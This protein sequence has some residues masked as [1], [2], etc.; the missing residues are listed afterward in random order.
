[1]APPDK[2]LLRVRVHQHLI[3]HLGP[4]KEVFEVTG[5]TLSGSPVKDFNVSY[6]APQGPQSPV[7]FS[8][9]GA[10]QFEMNDERR[11]EGL[12]ILHRK[13]KDE[14]ITSIQRL[15]R[16]FALFSESNDEAIRV[17]DVLE[18][19]GD[20]TS[21]CAMDAVLLIPPVPLS[22]KFRRLRLTESVDIEFLWLLP[23]YASEVDYTM[24]HGAQ[25]T[26]MLLAAQG[27]NAID[28]Q[29]PEADTQIR[30]D[31][32]EVTARRVFEEAAANQPHTPNPQP[33]STEQEGRPRSKQGSVD[34][35]HDGGGKIR[36]NRRPP[37]KRNTNPTDASPEPNP[38]ASQ[39]A[40]AGTAKPSTG[41]DDPNAHP[42][43]TR[44]DL[45]SGTMG[46]RSALRSKEASGAEPRPNV[47]MSKE[48]KRE[49]KQK[50][51]AELKKKAKEAAKFAAQQKKN[52]K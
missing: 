14:A 19:P 17:S 41:P 21:F 3:Q 23:V 8:T 22:P 6:F 15:L 10:F 13:P 16:F 5:S 25:A 43:E 30:P 27:L 2:N 37:K 18:T 38:R 39:G 11:V 42:S 48:E 46:K 32:A 24:E 47:A 28:P 31:Q 49:A 7:V 29:R 12:V 45:S 20:L 44:F 33:R 26:L 36:F 40:I 35:P 34:P 1:M 4:T 9:S 52:D 50:R 51:I